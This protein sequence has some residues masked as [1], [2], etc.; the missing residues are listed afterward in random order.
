LTAGVQYV[1]ETRDLRGSHPDTYMYLVRDN[2][3][4]AKNDDYNGYASLIAYVPSRT[5]NYCLIIRAFGKNSSG[6][7]DVYQAVGS[8][9]PTRIANNVKFGGYPFDAHWKADETTLTMNATGDTYLYLIDGNTMLRDDD[10]GEG[11]CSSIRPGYEGWGLVV[12]GSYSEHTEGTT[13]LCNYYQSYLSNPSR[14]VE[15]V[16]DPEII[17][18]EAMAKFQTE[19]MK[20]K[21]SLEEL[22]HQEREEGVQKLRD[23]ILSAE[24]IKRLG[25]PAMSVSKEFT[26]AYERYKELLKAAEK[27][28][29]PLS[30]AERAA[31]MARMEREKREIFGDLVPQEEE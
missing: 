10:S 17:I 6:T 24:D 15:V 9:S 20:E 2:T 27:K 5:D 13:Q 29:K 28:L 31:E 25:A 23:S 7:C 14:R 11:L 16:D 3:I 12:V 21:P 8:G 22:P 4:V 26:A 1:F 18:S 19:L 30:Y